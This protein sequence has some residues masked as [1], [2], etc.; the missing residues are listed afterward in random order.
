MR[1][2]AEEA[3]TLPICFEEVIGYEQQERKHIPKE[4][5]SVRLNSE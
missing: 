3:A 5:N 2:R 1:G 4:G